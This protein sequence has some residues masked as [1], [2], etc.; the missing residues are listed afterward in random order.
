MRKPLFDRM[1]REMKTLSAFCALKQEKCPFTSFR[2][3]LPYQLSARRLCYCHDFKR[4]YHGKPQTGLFVLGIDDLCSKGLS[5]LR[6]LL[7]PHM[8]KVQHTL[9]KDV[10]YA[11]NVVR[12]SLYVSSRHACRPPR[13]YLLP[14]GSPWC[15]SCVE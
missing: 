14:Y 5:I 4:Y 9:E 11:K 2:S 12:L 13:Q 3:T 10:L 8:K 7:S 1:P 6:S 15:T